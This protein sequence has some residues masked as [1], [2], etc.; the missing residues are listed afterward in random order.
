MK[1]RDRIVNGLGGVTLFSMSL[2]M[3]WLTVRFLEV[4]WT[5]ALLVQILWL[6][7]LNRW[8]QPSANPREE[9]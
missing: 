9:P 8:H 3:A 7:A 6:T 5:T 2:G 1:T 4:S